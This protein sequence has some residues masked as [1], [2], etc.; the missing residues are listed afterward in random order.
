[1]GRGKTEEGNREE[2]KI[3]AQALKALNP[4]KEK[5]GS[6]KTMFKMPKGAFDFVA[7]LG[8]ALNSSTR[9]TLDFIMK[10]TD[11][12]RE[13]LE[14]Y[15]IPEDSIRKSVS[16]SE[17]AKNTVTRLAK[18]LSWS[19]DEALYSI[20]ENIKSQLNQ[21]E[22]TMEEKVKYAR[23]LEKM[24]DEMIEIYDSPEAMEARQKL[25]AC[26]DP[27]LDETYGAA[28]ALPELIPYIEQIYCFQNGIEK[29][30]EKKE[31]NK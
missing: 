14:R 8:K 26:C 23:V 5:T 13:N 7:Q 22:L 1:M 19:R 9:E 2:F 27:D 18:K 6:G 15:E 30:I 12:T 25:F 28:E 3:S 10:L 20:I 24:A 11:K 16:I 21:K 17:E 31:N 29:F 4:K